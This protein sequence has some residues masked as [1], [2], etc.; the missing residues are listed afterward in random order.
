MWIISQE[1]SIYQVICANGELLAE[2][3]GK[4]RF[5]ATLP[6]D[7]PV[8]G[9]FVMLDRCTNKNGNVII[10]YVLHTKSLFVRKAV[11]KTSEGQVVAA[12]IT[13]ICFFIIAFTN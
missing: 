1:K 10:R 9:D 4:L 6:S 3:S 7:F 12:N 11:E 8:V 2:V 13:S 5:E